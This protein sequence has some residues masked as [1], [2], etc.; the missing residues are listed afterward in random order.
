MENLRKIINVIL[1]NN[2]KDYMMYATKPS[3]VSQKI[4]NE[5][6]VAIHE[7][8]PVLTHDKPIYVGFCILDLSKLLMYKFHYKYIKREFNAN[9]LSTDTDSLLSKIETN[10][11]YEDFHWDKS[12]F[13]FSDYP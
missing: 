1:V 9:L 11:V 2:A 6:F 8:I 5:N 4:F 3:F 12:L 13:E 10:D 7:I